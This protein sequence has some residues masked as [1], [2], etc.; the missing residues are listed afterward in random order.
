MNERETEIPT[1]IQRH[2]HGK[3]GTESLRERDRGG[4]PRVGDRADRPGEADRGVGYRQQIPLQS[5]GVSDACVQRETQ[6]LAEQKRHRVA[7]GQAR[8]QERGRKS[9]ASTG[10][11]LSIPRGRIG[12]LGAAVPERCPV[13][14]GSAIRGPPGGSCIPMPAVCS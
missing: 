11:S 7:A 9:V 12:H 3:E 5:D 10:I 6:Q 1:S 4:I 2:R 8:G 14:L 13:R